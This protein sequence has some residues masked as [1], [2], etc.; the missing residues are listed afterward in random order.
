MFYF[1]FYIYHFI[2]IFN[3]KYFSVE[4][5]Y[6]HS[7]IKF[8]LEKTQGQKG[9]LDKSNRHFGNACG[10]ICHLDEDRIPPNVL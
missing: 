2:F 3:D 6:A 9:K 1:S 5:F 8:L 4:G 10:I 7:I